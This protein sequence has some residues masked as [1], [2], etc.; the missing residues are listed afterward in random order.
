[1]CDS[2]VP[3]SSGKRNAAH[4][5]DSSTTRRS[6]AETSLSSHPSLWYAV[7]TVSRH[8]AYSDVRGGQE[9]RDGL[10]CTAQEQCL[11]IAP[12]A[13]GA[14][15]VVPPNAAGVQSTTMRLTHLRR[16]LRFRVSFRCGFFLHGLIH[17]AGLIAPG[18]S[19][20][21]DWRAGGRYTIAAR[22]GLRERDRPA[23]R[24]GLSHLVPV[25]VPVRA[26]GVRHDGR[27]KI[28]GSSL[29]PMK[30]RRHDG[31]EITLGSPD[32]REVGS[33]TPQ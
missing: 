21:D 20:H 18:A 16:K 29:C 9:K 25:R 33:S 7:L 22:P 2:A 1:M 31:S 32:K 28:G 24:P 11:D 19:E 17:P 8:C 30:V 26:P 10:S 27:Q 12:T 13:T 15:A 5:R 14:R 3:R 23:L 6:A 4:H